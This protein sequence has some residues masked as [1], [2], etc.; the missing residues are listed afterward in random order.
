MDIT[1]FQNRISEITALSSKPVSE[2]D[3]QI[4]RYK[5]EAR[6]KLTTLQAELSQLLCQNSANLDL[7][8]QLSQI[9]FLLGSNYYETEEMSSAAESLEAAQKQI[10]EYRGCTLENSTANKSTTEQIHSSQS[11]KG[12]HDDLLA[13]IYNHLGIVWS[14]RG[15]ATKA[16]L[17]LKGN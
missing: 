7:K 17:Y 5:Y 8:W 12:E 3:K 11:I 15:E 13:D 16:E 14:N 6:A 1:E 4:Y 10:E 9:H 2:D